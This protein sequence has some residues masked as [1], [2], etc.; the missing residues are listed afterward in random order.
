MTYEIHPSEIDMINNLGTP[1]RWT[2]KFK[3]GDFVCGV[4][5]I[6]LIMDIQ[7]RSGT[8]KYRLKRITP[9]PDASTSWT[10]VSFI[11]KHLHLLP[12]ERKAEI[13]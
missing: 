2:P 11:D 3:V 6:D 7:V 10:E 13:L 4:E 5:V 1:L 12:D 9:D 8:L